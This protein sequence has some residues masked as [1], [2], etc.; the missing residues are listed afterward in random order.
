MHCSVYLI[1]FVLLLHEEIASVYLEAFIG[2]NC[3][4]SKLDPPTNL[5]QSRHCGVSGSIK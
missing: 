4:P 2:P 3:I 1:I 5:G